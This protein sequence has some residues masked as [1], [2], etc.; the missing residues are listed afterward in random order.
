MF[1]GRAELRLIQSLAKCRL[2]EEY[3]AAQARGEVRRDG[4]NQSSAREDCIP[5]A[6]D[7]GLTHKEIHEAR[8]IRDAEQ[9]EPGIVR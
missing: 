3:D 4:G 5:T 2:A 9:A 6:A 7:I 1:G 8:E